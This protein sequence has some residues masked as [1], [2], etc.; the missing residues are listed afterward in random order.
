[1]LYEVITI[2]LVG[3]PTTASLPEG[4]F[5]FL[6]AV[7]KNSAGNDVNVGGIRPITIVNQ[8]VVESI[9]IN[10]DALDMQVGD[11][12]PLEAVVT[13]IHN[14]TELIWSSTDPAVA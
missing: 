13:P 6:Y 10:P 2:S 9:A 4:N 12:E 7:F 3:I 14:V 5:Y 1:M 8:I 11:V